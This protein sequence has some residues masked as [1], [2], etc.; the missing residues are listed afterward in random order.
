[1]KFFRRPEPGPTLRP[2]GNDPGLAELPQ[3]VGDDGFL[4]PGRGFVIPLDVF[5][6]PNNETGSVPLAPPPVDVADVHPPAVVV[7]EELIP[8]PGRTLVWSLVKVRICRRQLQ[9]VLL[10]VA[11]VVV[12][13]R[14]EQF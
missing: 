12:F 6:S 5:D 1:M 9:P 4:I 2:S 14:L 8:E 11:G 7:A 10:V 3:P 13:N